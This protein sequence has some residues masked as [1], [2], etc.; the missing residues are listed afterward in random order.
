MIDFVKNPSNFNMDEK[1]YIYT[2]IYILFKDIY[3]T[4]YIDL[5]NIFNKISIDDET[6]C[7]PRSFIDTIKEEETAEVQVQV[8][9]QNA[10][11]GNDSKVI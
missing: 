11:E 2:I 3:T 8:S 10:I 9:L 7:A 1:I 5:N 4:N 6:K